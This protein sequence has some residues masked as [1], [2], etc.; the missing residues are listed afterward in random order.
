MA[1]G[2]CLLQVAGGLS[3]SHGI[4]H[5]AEGFEMHGRSFA[6]RSK[7]E[8]SAPAWS[9]APEW[10]G[11]PMR[12]WKQ[13]EA[14]NPGPSQMDE[15]DTW[16]FDA[17]I[18]EQCDE[19]L[20]NLCWDEP[21]DEDEVLNCSLD[22]SAIAWNGDLAFTD[23]QLPAW[24]E[25]ERAAGLTSQRSTKRR[26]K[27]PSRPH[28]AAEQA[29]DG[30][31]GRRTFQGQLQHFEF[32]TGHLGTGY[33]D[34]R[35]STRPVIDATPQVLVLD[36]LIPLYSC[37]GAFFHQQVSED[38]REAR[39]S[40]RARR[41]RHPG[42]CRKALVSRRKKATSFSDSSSEWRLPDVTSIGDSSWKSMGLWAIDTANGNSWKT[43]LRQVVRRSAADILLLQE[44]KLLDAQKFEAAKITARSVGWNPTFSYAHETGSSKA[45]G[46]N[47]IF[48]RRGMGI[49]Q[50][51]DKAVRDGF[52]HRIAISWVDGVQR[53][54][55]HC[56]SIWLF[57]SQGLS[58]SNMALLEE[59]AIA[60]QLCQGGW[61]LGGD[62][63][64]PPELLKASKWLEMVNGVIFATPL[65]TC[66]D[67]TYD[68]F[69]VHR[70]L[71]HAVVGVQR[72]EDGGCTPHWQSRLLLRGDARRLA[73]R[74]LV[75]PPKVEAT[76]PLGPQ[77][78]PP[79]YSPVLQ[80]ADKQTLD[81]AMLEWLRK[82]RCE[83]NDLSGR[84]D[85]F[86]PA[87]FVWVAAAGQRAQQWL[88]A[89]DVSVMWRVMARRAQDSARII[90]GC[91][92]GASEG[93]QRALAGHLRAATHAACT[94]CN[95]KRAAVESQVSSW[96]GSM[97]AAVAAASL[98]WLHSLA[99]LADVKAKIGED[100]SYRASSRLWRARL[101]ASMC[102]QRHA[103][104]SKAAYR[105]VR[106]LVGWHH[107]PIGAVELNESIPEEGE[108]RD[109]D[110]I[111]HVP[112]LQSAMQ[113]PM[114]DQTVVEA[115]AEELAKL[116][117]EDSSYEEPDWQ[118]DEE[119]QHQLRQLLP[120]A[121]RNAAATFPAG[122]GLGADNIA[123]RAFARLSEEALGSLAALFAQFELIGR[124]ADVLS[125]ILIILL[126]KS[127]GGVRPIGLFPSVIRI[128][129]RARVYIARAWEAEHALPCLFGGQGMGAQRAAWEAAF[130]AEVAG[131]QRQEHL[132]ALLD[133]VKAFEM[134]PHALL[135]KAAREKGYNLA[136][137]RLSLAAYRLWR[138]VG[139]DGT[140]SRRVRATR[141]ITAGSGFATSELRVLLLGV[142]ERVREN[143][144]P[145]IASLKLYV[146]DLTI[147]VC[148]MIYRAT[149]LLVSIVD[150][151]IDILQTELRLEVSAKKSKVVAS[152]ADTA[153]A[154]AARVR[155][156][157]LQPA[158]HSRL[159]GTGVVGGRRN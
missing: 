59:A 117:Q 116:W 103:T 38:G 66:N 126:P 82:T 99:K 41:A 8:D 18:E 70:S 154:V 113:V 17:A 62:W 123:P 81:E 47:G 140:F 56:G 106:G 148:G 35:V 2:V 143:W 48:A 89:S 50:H 138:S 137:L 111:A 85:S 42:G 125:L 115:H 37:T 19:E 159:L 133:L 153:Q 10:A 5:E 83:W 77:R 32:K 94:L 45:T 12:G 130:A 22:A 16:D 118:D 97:R 90:G 49:N 55:L 9:E 52:R 54:G 58:E 135:V 15:A 155:S 39:S 132:Q 65:P 80:L 114:A 73:I 46:G 142:I 24:Q 63:N 145:Y 44:T 120:W 88:G 107:S 134:I 129:M 158:A 150:F 87:R 92:V 36:S 105:W 128:W 127:D 68:F 71:A 6:A 79:D 108:D 95:S 152:R 33:Y 122:T 78:P 30:F 149:R 74:K 57:D 86:R 84:E 4:A 93:Q 21:P 31:I 151:V 26:Q 34:V 7:A 119:K 157:K 136:I 109:A 121:I 64:M 40:K 146:D 147:G 69:V 110:P 20:P 102:S 124:W 144:S 141:G 76:L 28:L 51:T 100:A 112:D 91:M 23:Q 53:G 25:A 131:L 156:Q 1:A 104:P 13:G 27:M 43:V 11:W 96:A 60:L 29:V 14:S 3:E 61:V 72:V 139:V 101:G 75:K 67:S 98:S